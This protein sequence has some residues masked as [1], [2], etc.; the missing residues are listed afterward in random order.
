MSRMYNDNS[1]LHRDRSEINRNSLDFT[2]FEAGILID[3]GPND[4]QKS[5]AKLLQLARYEW[6]CAQ[7][8][9]T[10]L[11]SVVE[12]RVSN[13]LKGFCNANELFGQLYQV[14]D[15]GF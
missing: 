8:A 12:P 2:K 9:L 7:A 1:S 10:Q 11:S 13:I 6:K 5:E 3:H 14:K 4:P 15:L